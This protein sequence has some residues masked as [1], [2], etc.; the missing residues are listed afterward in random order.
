MKRTYSIVSG[1]AIIASLGIATAVHAHG[2]GFGPRAGSCMGNGP[3]MVQGNCP[4]QGP[5]MGYQGHGPMGG[6]IGMQGPQGMPGHRADRANFD[7][8]AMIEG[9]LAYLKSALKITDKQEAAWQA[10]GAKA[11]QQGV[12][13]QASRAALSAQ[14]ASGSAPERMT[15]RTAMMKQ[16][17]DNMETMNAALKDL[18]AVL[19]PEQKTIA[20]QHF[21]N[22]RMAFGG[23][24][25]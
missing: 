23:Q 1:I 7:P 2:G 19:T 11:K 17:I 24:P 5:N 15:Q 8:A 9:R 16:R 4:G 13:M 6:M 12:A 18:Y 22:M 10:Y 20:D 21:G 3:G 25:R 14:N